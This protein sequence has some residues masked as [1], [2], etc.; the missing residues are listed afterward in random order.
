MPS[1]S[2]LGKKLRRSGVARSPLP[3]SDLIGETFARGIEDRLRPLV[4]TTISATT[5]HPRVTRLADAAGAIVVPAMLGVVEIEDADTPGLIAGQSELAYHLVDLML[6]GDPATLP[7]AMP[8]ALTAIDMALCRLHLDAI[9]G[10]F[11]QAIGTSLGRPLT[12][13]LRIRDQ[14]QNLSQLR[15]GPDYIDVLQFEVSLRLGDGGREGGLSLILPLSALDV[16]RASIRELDARAAK[17]RP[18]DLW[19]SL[20][21]RTAAA[22]PV[23]VDAVLHRQALSLSALGDLKVGQVIEIPRQAAEEIQLSIRQPGGRVALLATGQL[24]AFQDRKV[25]KLGTSLD[26]RVSLHIERALRPA[27]SD[28]DTPPQPAS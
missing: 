6:G 26:R 2:V 21:R 3:D 22:A 16:I 28:S 27:R 14:R 13:A 15:L 11:V 17:D 5:S 1:T 24:G 23:T 10:A 9:L 12:K 20:M 19:K 8:R 4:K 18:N 7:R 25:V